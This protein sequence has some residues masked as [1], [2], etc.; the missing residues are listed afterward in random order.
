MD[1]IAIPRPLTSSRLHPPHSRHTAGSRISLISKKNIRYDG[2]LYSINEADATVALEN[3]R[4]YGTEGRELLDTTGASTFVPPQD[5]VHAYL[6][7]RGQDI[8]DLH[9]HETTV[10]E[11]AATP[12]E[13]DDAAG[14]ETAPSA[15]KAERS[16]EKGEAVPSPPKAR[17]AQVK[18]EKTA[19]KKPVEKKGDA[20][21]NNAAGAKSTP[22]GTTSNSTSDA[23]AE[24]SQGHRPAQPK[25]NVPKRKNGNMVGTGASLLNK[26]LRG[27]KGDQGIPEDAEFDFE[28]NLAE[29][30]KV[31]ISSKDNHANDGDDTK[32]NEEEINNSNNN[33][34]SK[35]DFFDSIS[36]DALD[37]QNGI[38]N[39]LRGA[40]ERSLNLDTFGA[41]SLGHA[42]RG[43]RGRGG[44][45]GGRGGRG[46][47]GG[48]RGRG[49]GG[50]RSYTNNSSREGYSGSSG[51]S[52][53]YERGNGPA[54]RQNNRWKE[55]SS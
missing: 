20:S 5:V 12:K 19:S 52:G 13:K 32:E 48:Y 45:G 3:V 4:S 43:G 28:S 11:E 42:R 1:A 26:N 24:G 50:G 14:R 40:A 46:A 34:Y 54:P 17:G 30:D 18:E 35:N 16:E 38:D 47:R 36:C 25:K 37:K 33:V 8:K 51:R 27:G 55:T 41:V 6:L 9:V 7:F 31:E 10:E 22:G 29:F 15:E 53:G 39:R 49:S 21:R 44:R 2:T 23:K